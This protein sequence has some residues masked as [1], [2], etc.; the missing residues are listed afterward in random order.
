MNWHGLC[1]RLIF[2]MRLII[3]GLVLFIGLTSYGQ[4]DTLL[5]SDTTSV[6]QKKNTTRN[7]GTA[8]LYSLI[9]GGGQVYNRKYWKI[10][11][12]YGGLILVGSWVV[13]NNKQ[14]K[15][16]KEEAINRYN[17]D[18]II[19]FP[20]LNDESVVAEMENYEYKRNINIILLVGVYVLNIVDA[21]VDAYFFSYD[22]NE[23]LTLKAEPYI[24]PPATYSTVL[25]TAGITLTLNL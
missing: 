17:N 6:V 12:V 18:T 25:P 20:E 24:H 15:L 21:A 3:I 2:N 13:K 4:T 10:P 14:Y 16:Y 7:P 8:A 22:I 9:P 19:S 23:N 11:I 5:T 1:K